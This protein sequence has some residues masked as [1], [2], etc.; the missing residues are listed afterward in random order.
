MDSSSSESYSSQTSSSESDGI[1][2]DVGEGGGTRKRRR[3]VRRSNYLQGNCRKVYKLNESLDQSLL[4]C[5]ITIRG[6]CSS[7][8][9]SLAQI[10]DGFK[11]LKH[12]G[13][14]LKKK[15][16]RLQEPKDPDRDP[17]RNVS[18]Q[19]EWIRSNLFDAMV[20]TSS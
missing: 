18:M 4:E 19:N 2:S 17:Y 10:A 11:Q 6:V 7:C 1:S 20:I 13:T 9:S 5:D 15:K 12:H 3:H 14:E 16:W 8:V